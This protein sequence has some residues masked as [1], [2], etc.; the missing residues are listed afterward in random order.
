MARFQFRLETLLKI[1]LSE[2]QSRT[3]ALAEV[4]RADGL[5]D[6]QLQQL[7]LESKAM[8]QQL[9]LAASPGAVNVDRI[10]EVDR[11]ELVLLSQQRN[12]LQKKSTL[13]GEIA[14]RR[15]ALAAAEQEVRI[16]EKLRER[17][18]EDHQREDL[19]REQKLMDEVARARTHGRQP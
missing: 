2:R 10:L 13:K 12:V 14:R 1:R 7:R 3:A 5:L 15:D 9:R 11:F 4:V 8:K 6:D 16:L 18:L 19:R 17:R